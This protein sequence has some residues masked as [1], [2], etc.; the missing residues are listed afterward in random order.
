M[1]FSGIGGRRMGRSSTGKWKISQISEIIWKMS[2]FVRT[3]ASLRQQNIPATRARN[4]GDHPA[5]NGGYR[6]VLHKLTIIINCNES[7]NVKLFV[8]IIERNVQFEPWLSWE[9]IAVE[10][11]EN[12]FQCICFWRTSNQIQKKSTSKK[13]PQKTHI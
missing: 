12:I 2:H 13:I 1:M 5:Y 6:W 7:K 10:H 9:T 3:Q 4:I 8:L 11:P